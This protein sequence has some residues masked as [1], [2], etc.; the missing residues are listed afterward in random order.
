MKKI[1]AFLILIAA[2]PAT[3]GAGPLLTTLGEARPFTTEE[4]A[5]LLPVFLLVVALLLLIDY[6]WLGAKKKP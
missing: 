2:F 1:T 4:L 3:A 6:W 5:Y